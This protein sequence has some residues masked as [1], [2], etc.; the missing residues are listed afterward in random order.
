MREKFNLNDW[1]DTPKQQAID[2]EPKQET[3]T[4][5]SKAQAKQEAP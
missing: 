1:V 2:T 5:T 4:K 3:T